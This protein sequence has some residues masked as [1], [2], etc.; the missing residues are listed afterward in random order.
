M[1]AGR[2][3]VPHAAEPTTERWAGPNEL[4]PQEQQP[5]SAEHVFSPRTAARAQSRDGSRPRRGPA[6]PNGVTE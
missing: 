6:P 4:E 5:C 2:G 3:P 1:T